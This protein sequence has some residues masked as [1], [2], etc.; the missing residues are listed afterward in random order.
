MVIQ[1]PTNVQRP[2]AIYRFENSS[3]KLV[4]L[5]DLVILW[6]CVASYGSV[7]RF[8]DHLC[9]IFEQTKS[10]FSDMLKQLNHLLDEYKDQ[11][12]CPWFLQRLIWPKYMFYQESHLK[13]PY[14]QIQKCMLYLYFEGL[15]PSLQHVQ[16]YLTKVLF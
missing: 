3:N 12:K 11:G 9:L 1:I 4:F 7:F 10:Y 5:I 14:T 15:V 6:F 8:I 13:D 16:E 2:Q